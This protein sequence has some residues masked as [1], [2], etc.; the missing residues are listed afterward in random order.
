MKPLHFIA[1][2]LSVLFLCVP[3]TLAYEPE[4]SVTH[5]HNLASFEINLK[6]YAEAR[7]CS[8]VGYSFSEEEVSVIAT[9][10]KDWAENTLGIVEYTRNKVW[11]EVRS[12]IETQYAERVALGFPPISETNCYLVNQQIPGHLRYPKIETAPVTISDEESPI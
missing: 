4:V 10:M 12:E 6:L 5:K 9:L 7:D 2:Q 8:S 11:N 3:Q 1:V